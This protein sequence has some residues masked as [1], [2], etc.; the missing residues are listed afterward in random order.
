[1]DLPFEI[2]HEFVAYLKPFRAFHRLAACSETL[3]EQLSRIA[4]ED[5]NFVEGIWVGECHLPFLQKG[6]IHVWD[7]ISQRK[8][9][10]VSAR[11]GGKLKV[12]YDFNSPDVIDCYTELEYHCY[13]EVDAFRRELWFNSIEVSDVSQLTYSTIQKFDTF[14]VTKKCSLSDD[15]MQRVANLLMRLAENT[16]RLVY[17]SANC[18]IPVP[19]KLERE[20]K[21]LFPT[22]GNAYFVHGHTYADV[23]LVAFGR[24]T[25]KLIAQGKQQSIIFPL[26]IDSCASFD[27]VLRRGPFYTKAEL[28][29]VDPL[30]IVL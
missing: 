24:D 28:C 14:Y 25:T 3:H 15:F 13:Y 8:F 10:E 9:L 22:R 4:S 30:Q 11:T 18:V 23:C 19:A 2:L 12:E 21:T 16:K 5:K 26:I 29:I 7:W 1:M 27:D 20:H 17:T 6:V